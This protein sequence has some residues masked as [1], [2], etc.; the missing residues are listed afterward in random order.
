[1]TVVLRAAV[2]DLPF[3]IAVAAM[4]AVGLMAAGWAMG[5]GS[6]DHGVIV[7]SRQASGSGGGTTAPSASVVPSARPPTGYVV[8]PGDTLRA[9]AHRVLGD[10]A[11]WTAILDANRDRIGDPENLPIGVTLR[12]PPT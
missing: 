2:T 3:R 1:M 12:M 7:E 10:E 5:M 4:L 9:I 6:R 8:R 11:R